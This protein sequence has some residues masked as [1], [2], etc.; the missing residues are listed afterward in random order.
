MLTNFKESFHFRY[1]LLSLHVPIQYSSCVV[2]LAMMPHLIRR[3]DIKKGN[4]V[5]LVPVDNNHSLHATQMYLIG[6]AL[7]FIHFISNHNG[8]EPAST[9]YPNRKAAL[10]EVA[11]VTP[12]FSKK[13]DGAYRPVHQVQAS[14]VSVLFFPGLSP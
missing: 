8:S 7:H 1:N 4:S 6:A 5:L 2:Q 12:D 10:L 14:P 3:W 11:P 13:G 9:I